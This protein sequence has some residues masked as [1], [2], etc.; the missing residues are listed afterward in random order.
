MG[1]YFLTKSDIILGT[2]CF[3]KGSLQ[4]NVPRNT[5]FLV[6]GKIHERELILESLLKNRRHL[7][8]SIECVCEK[9]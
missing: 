2:I 3:E 8:D 5:Q 4:K 6:D 1:K 7:L 9:L